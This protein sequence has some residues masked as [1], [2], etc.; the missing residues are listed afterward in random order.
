MG[1]GTASATRALGPVRGSPPL[2]R[3]AG[4]LGSLALT[5]IGLTAITF[6]IGRVMPVDPVLAIVG[7]RASNEVYQQVYRQLGLD[8]PVYVQYLRYLGQL[9]AGD[10]GTS[11][12]TA[13]PVAEDIRRF[14]P[15]T[16]ELATV[17]TL[18]GVFIGIPMGVFAAWKAAKQ[19]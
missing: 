4:F 13:R 7:D 11:I 12:M 9:F 10:L 16:L 2:L 1:E 6:V 5:F 19:K 14:F 8:Q 17:A 18:L 15:A 3:I